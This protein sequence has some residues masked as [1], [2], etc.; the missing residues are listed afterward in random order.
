VETEGQCE[1][2]LGRLRD[3]RRDSKD[4]SQGDVRLASGGLTGDAIIYFENAIIRP[5]RSSIS[6]GTDGPEGSLINVVDTFYI[7]VNDGFTGYRTFNV[8]S[9]AIESIPENAKSIHLTKWQ[10]GLIVDNK[11]AAILSFPRAG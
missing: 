7:R 2:L 8:Q 6:T 11:F 9:G 10:A 3:H 1:L 4:R 5:D